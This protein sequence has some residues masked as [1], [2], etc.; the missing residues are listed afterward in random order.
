MTITGKFER[1]QYFNFE[2]N[3]LKNKNLFQKTGVPVLVEN[4]K[5]ENTTFQYKSALLESNVKIN[6]MRNIKWT[7]HKERSFV[8]NCLVFFFKVLF[9]F[10]NF[11]WRDDFMYQLPKCPYSCYS[12]SLEFHLRVLFPCEYP[13][14]VLKVFVFEFLIWNS[15][16][17]G[18]TFACYFENFLHT[19]TNI[20]K[21][22]VMSTPKC[23][24]VYAP[25][26]PF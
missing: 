18:H 15:F 8:S 12:Q 16:F 17:T 2:T 11:L 1:F 14:G 20:V 22:Q 19:S 25:I 6:R 7:Y 4:T 10:K 13:E 26:Y 5:I 24:H 9:Q 3:F 23:S 21:S